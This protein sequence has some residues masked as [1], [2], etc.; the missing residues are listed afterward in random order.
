MKG[1]GWLTFGILAAGFGLAVTGCDSGPRQ[2]S[3]SERSE[4][5]LRDPMNYRADFSRSR[6]TSGGIGTLDKEGLKRDLDRVLN[7]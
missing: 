2:P 5:A 3:L 7:P 6:V 4:Q 1:V